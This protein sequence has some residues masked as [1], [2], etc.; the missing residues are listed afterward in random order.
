M[1]C[2]AMGKKKKPNWEL[3]IKIFK[4]FL[5]VRCV[6]ELLVLC[7]LDVGSWERSVR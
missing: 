7:P 6:R 1:C 3:E 4:A 5:A 2:L